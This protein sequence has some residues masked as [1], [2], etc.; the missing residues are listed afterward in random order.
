MIP[1]IAEL[2]P[3]F[4]SHGEHFSDWLSAFG[5]NGEPL[6]DYGPV[7]DVRS[8][9]APAI[10]PD[11]KVVFG[12]RDRTALTHA[13][14]PQSGEIVWS[15]PFSSREPLVD[16]NGNLYTS[17]HSGLDKVDG[18]TG[19][20]LWDTV[21]NASPPAAISLDEHTLYTRYNYSEDGIFAKFGLQAVNAEDGSTRWR[22]TPDRSDMAAAGLEHD[23]LSNW[24]TPVVG[25]NG[26]VFVQDA[27]A[28]VLYA[29]RD[30]G[31]SVEQLWEYWPASAEVIRPFEAGSG[32]F[33][34]YNATGDGPRLVATD[35]EA[36]YMG[37]FARHAFGG[38][39]AS[40]HAVNMDG[41]SIWH[42]PVEGDVVLGSPVV[43][44]DAVYILGG[45]NRDFPGTNALY[46]LDRDDGQIL[47]QMNVCPPHGDVS[48]SIALAPDGT[49]YVATTDP[50]GSGSILRALR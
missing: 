35:G 27:D 47:W 25:G 4:V 38:Y 44:N 15:G 13:F 36:V 30:N 14:D 8:Y 16:S 31:D 26:I 20:A 10:L 5:P 9:G 32:K 41:E 18:A 34:I 2:H 23:F 28:N 21:P 39:P 46:C 49:I 50:D 7:N 3:I 29:I 22:F 24:A 33:F 17:S 6:W 48:E 37:V 19:A 45:G 43:T 42:T 11:G 1:V 40:V 12:F